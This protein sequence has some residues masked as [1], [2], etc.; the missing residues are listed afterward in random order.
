MTAPPPPFNQSHDVFISYSGKDKATADKICEYLEL[1]GIKCWI[2]PRDISYSD[3][4]SGAIVEAIRSSRIFILVFSSSSNSS[5]D[6]MQEVERAFQNEIPI[7]PFRVENVQP[8][9]DLEYFLSTP[10]WLNA[11]TPPL[12]FHLENL[13]DSVSSLL[14]IPRKTKRKEISRLSS[15]PKKIPVGVALALVIAA[16]LYF[17]PFKLFSSEDF[18]TQFSGAVDRL[19]STNLQ[20]QLEGLRSL[21]KIAETGG[22]YWYW[23]VMVQLTGYVKE[24]APWKGTG[25]PD[26][27][28][29]T[30]PAAA[31]QSIL[32]VISARPALYPAHFKDQDKDKQKRDLK[33]TDLRGLRLVHKAQLEYVDLEGSNLEGTVLTGANFKGAILKDAILVNADLGSTNLEGVDLGGADLHKANLRAAEKLNINNLILAERWWCASLSDESWKQIPDELK[34]EATREGCT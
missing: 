23:Q 33:C 2:A 14:K 3:S 29:K 32:E 1:Q 31:I 16:V 30:R 28:P 26:H 24:H 34:E 13:V 10:Q 17:D 22:E 25:C 8:S 6:V 15:I 19:S 27:T 7:L 9:T 20:Q 21:D 5:N 4:Y 18:N 11:L 12:E